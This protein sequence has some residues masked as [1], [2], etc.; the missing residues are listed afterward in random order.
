MAKREINRQTEVEAEIPVQKGTDSKT[1]Q[2]SEKQPPAPV[3]VNTDS[4]PLDVSVTMKS[5]GTFVVRVWSGA[6]LFAGKGK[7]NKI[8]IVPGKPINIRITQ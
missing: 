1:E 8:S 4:K 7:M 5:P 6:V 2:A 3:P